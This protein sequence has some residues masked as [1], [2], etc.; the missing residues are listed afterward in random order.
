MSP[1]NEPKQALNDTLATFGAR[2]RARRTELGL[3]QEAAAIRCGVH[4]SYYARAERGQRSSRVET[5]M[6]LAHGLDT[7]PGA[8]M[9]G[10]PFEDEG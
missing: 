3:S 6:R 5:V 8:L 7:T 4:S 10:L 1:A 2:L 9:D